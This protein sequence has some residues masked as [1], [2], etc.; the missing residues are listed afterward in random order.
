MDGTY[1]CFITLSTI[2]FGDFV[3]GANLQS[4]ENQ[5]KFVLCNL[6]IMVGLALLAM[7]FNLMQEEVQA[8]CRWLGTKLGLIS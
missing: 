6:Y 7:C 4:K 3:P 1:F 2:G 5:E 8:K